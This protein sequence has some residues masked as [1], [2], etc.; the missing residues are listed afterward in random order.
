MSQI[1]A[2]LPVLMIPKTMNVNLGYKL[3]HY[4]FACKC[5]EKDCTYTL[6]SQDLIC[7]WNAVRRVANMP[8][9]INSGYRCQKHNSNPAIKG[10]PTSRHKSGH[11]I[12]I[13]I[14]RLDE[15]NRAKVLET[16]RIF[17]DVVIEYPTFMHCHMEPDSRKAVF[18][19]QHMEE[20]K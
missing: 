13:F 11:A 17:F 16:A 7:G 15:K 9:S 2:V 3:W 8:L 20:S 12:D 19:G 14:G 4:E 10:V 1:K 5:T 18:V 6:V